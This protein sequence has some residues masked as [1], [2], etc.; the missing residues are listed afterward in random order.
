MA[1]IGKPRDRQPLLEKH[2]WALWWCGAQDTQTLRVSHSVVCT[3]KNKS[4]QFGEHGVAILAWQGSHQLTC[5]TKR[6]MHSDVF[7][8]NFVFFPKEIAMQ[9]LPLGLP[10]GVI[11][12]AKWWY[13][14]L[15]SV[16]NPLVTFDRWHEV[17]NLFFCWQVS[18]QTRSW[19][20]TWLTICWNTFLLYAIRSSISSV[21]QSGCRPGLANHCPIMLCLTSVRALPC[22]DFNPIH[23]LSE[24]QDA[25][26]CCLVSSIQCTSGCK[27]CLGHRLLQLWRLLSAPMTLRW[28]RTLWSRFAALG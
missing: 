11:V 16:A 7:S 3:L 25:T 21:R 1:R 12:W 15:S 9:T 28:P 6:W 5:R 19:A 4:W 8:F 17:S 27:S 26:C 20:R 14:V 10:A 2:S 13:T 23:W 24:F 18:R 22:S